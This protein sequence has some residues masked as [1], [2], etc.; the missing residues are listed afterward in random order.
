MVS[1][2]SVYHVR[3]GIVEE[4]CSTHGGQEGEKDRER[5]NERMQILSSFTPFIL[6]RS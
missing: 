6:P 2:I 5:E 1:D 4:S 3:E